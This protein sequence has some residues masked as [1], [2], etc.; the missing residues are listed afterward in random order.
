MIDSLWGFFSFFFWGNEKLNFQLV[1]DKDR[2]QAIFSTKIAY[3]LFENKENALSTCYIYFVLFYFALW[4]R[5]FFALQS[6]FTFSR[7]CFFSTSAPLSLNVV[8]LFKDFLFFLG[9]SLIDLKLVLLLLWNCCS[10]ANF[11]LSKCKVTF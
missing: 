10:C 2:A 6:I 9:K 5:N 1:K 3:W 7:S 11:S 4:M 8:N